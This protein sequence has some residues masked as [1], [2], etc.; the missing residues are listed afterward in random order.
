MAQSVHLVS[1]FK[2]IC[3][4]FCFSGDAPK[5]QV[6]GQRFHRILALTRAYCLSAFGRPV[7]CFPHGTSNAPSLEMQPLSM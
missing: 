6:P 5:D 7:L 2:A 1:P 4:A 3:P